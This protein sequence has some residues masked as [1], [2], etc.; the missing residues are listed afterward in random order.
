MS[1]EYTDYVMHFQRPVHTDVMKALY[2]LGLNCAIK[3]DRWAGIKKHSDFYVLIE[4]TQYSH[5]VT[6]WRAE[7]LTDITKVDSER[8]KD[9]IP[10]SPN[11]DLIL[12][13]KEI[14]KLRA[15]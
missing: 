12:R 1:L 4:A 7:V 10:L 5:E 6:L 15:G 11:I 14:H 13:V 8:R 3:Q 2:K 9:L